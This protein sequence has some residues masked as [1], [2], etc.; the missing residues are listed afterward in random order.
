MGDVTLAR[1]RTAVCA[2]RFAAC[3]VLCMSRV[4]FAEPALDSTGPQVLAPAQGA[5]GAI[6]SFHRVQPGETLW[7]I[8]RNHAIDL[9]ALAHANG[10]GDAS[11][12]ASG[13]LLVLPGSEAGGA[14]PRREDVSDWLAR[15][16]AASAAARFEQAHALIR[17]IRAL[18][19]DH[20]SSIQ[21]LRLE[22]ADATVALAFGRREDAIA[23]LTRALGVDPDLALE[24]GA[25]SPKLEAALEAARAR[26]AQRVPLPAVSAPS[27]AAADARAPDPPG[28]LDPLRAP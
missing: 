9:R 6:L 19:W 5:P 1:I 14:Q 26:R 2:A 17:S 11:E 16:E 18:L 27:P 24:P 7:R 10:I 22:Q 3:I 20:A 12:I 25:Q 23:C 15:A 21:R 28:A 13:Q 8:A 4:A